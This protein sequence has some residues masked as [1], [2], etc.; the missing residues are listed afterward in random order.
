M[1]QVNSYFK[2]N[3]EGERAV[4]K[5]YPPLEGGARL[6]FQ[7]V[8]DYL[9]KRGYNSLDVIAIGRAL[10]ADVKCKILLATGKKY[11]ESEDV[12]LTV[13]ED[14]MEVVARF[15]PASDGGH[16]MDKEDIIK[17]LDSK[18]IIYGI[19][20]E[21]IDAFIEHRV[22]CTDFVIA[23]GL[24]PVDGHNAEITYHFH[25]EKSM[26]PKENEDG[27]V[28]FHSL[29]N[30]NRV[31]K[32]DCLATMTPVDY[33]TYGKNVLGEN[34]SPR[35]VNSL[36][37]KYGKN[38]YE[39]DD[40]LK[41]FSDVEGHVELQ[42]DTVFVSDTYEIPEN[43]G[44]STGDINYT[45]NVHIKGN[46]MSGFT[47]RARGNITVD[48]VVEC[49]V[50]DAGGSIILKSGIQGGKRGILRARKDIV[51]KF[52]EN[53]I[54]RAGGKITTEA[55][56]YS[57]VSA[58]DVIEVMGKKGFIVGGI[59]RSK[60]CVICKSA[61]STMETKTEIEVG[62][63]PHIIEEA[64]QLEKT[65]AELHIEQEKNNQLMAVLSNRL[66]QGKLKEDG[67]LQLKKVSEKYMECTKQLE[68]D[69]ARLTVVNEEIQTMGNGTFEVLHIAYV[70][71][72][73]I[74]GN[75]V[76]Y[77]RDDAKRKRF[78]LVNNSIVTEQI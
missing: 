49:A 12:K 57:D 44:L 59:T 9:N 1:K 35:K 75:N 15:Y 18:G 8:S 52:L 45:G 3:I 46:V 36:K 64:A 77:F 60:N 76:H 14:K 70:G 17:L 56:L 51:S 43:V 6:D 30:I 42:G 11:P 47:V 27:T 58:G 4:L 21:S 73:L 16:A 20:E 68:K 62:V 5:I 78:R 38:I 74:I 71:V 31:N 48:G 72:K 23:K 63:D 26:K 2:L 40:K 25:L 33:G 65:I 69:T 7:E 22:Y 10:M 50:L 53:A 39:S 61:G 13:S 19:D 34:I 41:I 37:F 54:V 55:I 66:N 67:L 28:D 29:D 32:G 24:A